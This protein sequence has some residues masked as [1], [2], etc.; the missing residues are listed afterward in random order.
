VI[1]PPCLACNVVGHY[2]SECPWDMLAQARAPLVGV[3]HEL[4][5]RAGPAAASA[6][7]AVMVEPIAK[8]QLVASVTAMAQAT[9]ADQATP[10]QAGAAPRGQTMITRKSWPAAVGK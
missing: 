6:V 10:G 2:K 8:A 4:A 5:Q 1:Q 9:Q 3:I 7:G